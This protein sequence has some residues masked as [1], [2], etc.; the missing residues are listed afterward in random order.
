MGHRESN[1]GEFQR[2]NG[3]LV[4]IPPSLRRPSPLVL[5]SPRFFVLRDGLERLSIVIN[6]LAKAK[7]N[8]KKINLA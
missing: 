7:N 1:L 3:Y 2:E 4:F 8:E 5:L 6:Q